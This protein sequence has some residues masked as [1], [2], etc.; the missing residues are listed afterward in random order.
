MNDLTPDDLI[1]A[2]K[3]QDNLEQIVKSVL[4]A[5]VNLGISAMS[6]TMAESA[7][8]GKANI[9]DADEIEKMVEI[10]RDKA[11]TKLEEKMRH[12]KENGS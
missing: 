1:Q 6:L 11:I 12:K 2:W 5:G 8:Q 4:Y 10:A 7:L 3:A 9:T